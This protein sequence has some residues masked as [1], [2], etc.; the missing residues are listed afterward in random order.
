[1]PYIQEMPICNVGKEHSVIGWTSLSLLL[2]MF[3]KLN[4]TTSSLSQYT[5]LAQDKWVICSFTAFSY[6]D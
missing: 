5:F 3:R 4:M 6:N 2:N 1:M